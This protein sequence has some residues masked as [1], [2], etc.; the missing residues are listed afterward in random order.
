MIA[1]ITNNR[2]AVQFSADAAG[3]IVPSCCRA[4]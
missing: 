2:I 4:L 3:A 1:S